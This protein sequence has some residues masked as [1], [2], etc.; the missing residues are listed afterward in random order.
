M[1]GMEKQE[2]KLFYDR[3]SDLVHSVERDWTARFSFFLD[4]RQQALASRFLQY[5]GFHGFK[6]YGGFEKAGRKVL[7]LFPEYMEGE[8]SDFP[9]EAVTLGYRAEDKPRHQD[10][11]GTL[12]GLNIKRELI[13][14]I[15][16]GEEYAV[17]FL[18]EPAN[19]LVLSEVKKI[20]RA[21]VRTESGLP[22]VLPEP[23]TL[24]PIGGTVSSLRLDCL[25]AFFTN[26]SREK[27]SQLIRSGQVSVNFFEVDEISH[28][29]EEG[30]IFSIRGHGRF[31]LSKVGGLSQKGR[32]HLLGHQY[33]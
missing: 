2:E 1:S 33:V 21:G 17:I 12:M 8:P 4:E 26:L 15:L 9:I 11:L 3:L 14:D 18:L 31:V 24:K 19:T 20:G 30:D 7:G 28:T 16:I 5:S 25:V 32:L 10:I 23:Y 13:G 29:V 6:L 27:A 22:A